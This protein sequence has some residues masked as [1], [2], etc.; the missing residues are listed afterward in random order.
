MKLY[1]QLV[2]YFLVAGALFGLA[3]GVLI[4]IATNGIVGLGYGVLAGALLMFGVPLIL[5]IAGHKNRAAGGPN[6]CALGTAQPPDGA[7]L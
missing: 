6:R 5:V 2:R 4:V 3:M 7:A 1:W